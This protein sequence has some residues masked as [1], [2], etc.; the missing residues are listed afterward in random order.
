MSL[1][2]DLKYSHTDTTIAGR[3]GGGGGGRGGAGLTMPGV[4]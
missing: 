1:S 3:G 4:N 2:R